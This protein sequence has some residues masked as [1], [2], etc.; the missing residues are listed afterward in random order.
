MGYQWLAAVAAIST[1]GLTAASPAW[2]AYG[3]R[4][5]ATIAWHHLTST[6]KQGVVALLR[7]APANAGLWQR[8]PKSTTPLEQAGPRILSV[9]AVWADD[10]K[11]A[12]HAGNQYDV[13]SWHYTDL[14]W[15]VSPGGNPELVSQQPEGELVAKLHEFRVAIRDGVGSEGERA[16]ALAWLIHLGGDIHQPLHWL[17]R[18]FE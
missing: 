9:A 6:A 4:V 7:S 1:G 2:D 16:R 11:D 13:R 3:H 10:I 14:F 15:R 5:V 12:Q 17:N 8:F 18:L